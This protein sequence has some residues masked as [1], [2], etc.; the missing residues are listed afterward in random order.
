MT[1]PPATAVP[2]AFTVL[3]P[4][5]EAVLGEAPRLERVVAADAHE[6]PVYAGDEDALYFTS[7]PC[8]TDR[9]GRVLPLVAIRRVALDG[10]RFGLE[11]RRVTTVRAPANAA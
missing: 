4:A 7:V 8:R 1:S 6:G 11:P 3:S 10:L 9:L 2:P 5:F